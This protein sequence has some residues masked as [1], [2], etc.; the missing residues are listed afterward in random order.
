MADGLGDSCAQ[1]LQSIRVTECSGQGSEIESGAYRLETV[2]MDV[3][4]YQLRG[5]EMEN[6]QSTDI[7]PERLEDDTPQAR[8]VPL[9]NK[10]LDGIWE[11]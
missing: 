3:Q 7:A 5:A 1:Y 6:T 2:E 11:S 10:E 8:I 9:P 4:A